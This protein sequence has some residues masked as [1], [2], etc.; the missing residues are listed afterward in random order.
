MTLYRAG[1]NEE[2]FDFASSG[3]FQTGPNTLEGKQFLRTDLAV[4][5]FAGEANRIGY[6]PPYTTVFA[7]SI[8]ESDF[9][10]IPVDRQILDSHEAITVSTDLVAFN[11]CINFTKTYAFQDNL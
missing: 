5:E 4:R 1:S 2:L 9:N 7:I 10:R 11:N 8:N 6:E 3:V